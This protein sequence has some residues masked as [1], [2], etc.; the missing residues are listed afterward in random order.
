[1]QNAD[2]SEK[3]CCY[4]SDQSNYILLCI[5]ETIQNFW[6]L[7]VLKKCMWV[8]IYSTSWRAHRK[9]TVICIKD[10]GAQW[11]VLGMSY[12]NSI[13]DEV[14]ITAYI[15]I[16]QIFEGANLH[17]SKT[18]VFQFDT[19]NDL[20]SKESSLVLNISNTIKRKNSL[21][22]AVSLDLSVSSDV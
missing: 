3:K 2:E 18:Q 10:F 11:R 15:N 16:C 14:L 1:M 19:L 13:F 9:C 5:S 6:R 12:K 4:Q 17:Y 8:D 7:P 21:Y 22:L 20:I